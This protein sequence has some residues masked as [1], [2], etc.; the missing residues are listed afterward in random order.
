MDAHA[1][2]ASGFKSDGIEVMRVDA[3]RSRPA[4]LPAAGGNAGPTVARVL[5]VTSTLGLAA[6]RPSPEP[7]F[8]K[9]PPGLT[10]ELFAPGLVGTDAVEL[11]WASR[12]I[13][14]VY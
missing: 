12:R 8:G 13:D 4:K 1:R 3:S 11:D 9:P 5:I 10:P 6:A 7:H 2:Q 14:D